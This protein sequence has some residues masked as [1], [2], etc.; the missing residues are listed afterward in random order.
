MTFETINTFNLVVAV[1]FVIMHNFGEQ[2]VKDAIM[3][4]EE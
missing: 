1:K 4:S 2:L 3:C